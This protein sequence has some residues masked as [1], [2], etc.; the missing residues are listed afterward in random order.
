MGNKQGGQEHQILWGNYLI[1]VVIQCQQVINSRA[2]KCMVKNSKAVNGLK[3]V[4]LYTNVIC[5]RIKFPLAVFNFTVFVAL[6][7]CVAVQLGQ[8]PTWMFFQCFCAMTLFY[9]AHWQTYVSGTMKFGRVDV[10]EAQCTII[11]IHL[12]SAV[13]GPS[14]WMTEVIQI[15]KICHL[16]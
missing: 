2:T 8:Y 16:I 14:V 9:C 10:T 1:M 4:N 13:F 12:I 5:L 15:F 11:L 6:S 7:A 3:N